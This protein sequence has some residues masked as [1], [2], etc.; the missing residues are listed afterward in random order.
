MLLSVILSRLLLVQKW[1]KNNNRCL[2]SDVDLS[3]QWTSALVSSVVADLDSYMEGTAEKKVKERNCI[4]LEIKVYE[5]TNE[6]PT[7]QLQG[8]RYNFWDSEGHMGERYT[9]YC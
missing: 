1:Q 3:F 2:S 4:K 8:S 9:Y 5:P 6:R 7:V